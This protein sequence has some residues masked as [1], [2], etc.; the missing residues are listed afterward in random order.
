MQT[1]GGRQVQYDLSVSIV[2]ADSIAIARADPGG[3]SRVTR[4]VTQRHGEAAEAAAKAR[5]REVLL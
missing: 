3:V 2:H 1:H 4:D 5:S